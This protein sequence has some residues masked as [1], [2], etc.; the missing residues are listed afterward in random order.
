MQIM[1][2]GCG[3]VGYTL[4]DQLSGEEDH[5]IIVV[6]R[7]PDRISRV[8]NDFDV[9]GYVG[10]GAS[11]SVLKEA[12][13]DNTDLL[14]AVTDSD[15]RNLLCSLIAKKAGNCKAIA[16]VRNPIYSSEG[17]FLKRELGLAMII[18]PEYA[19]ASEMARIFRFPSAIKIDTFAK[20][21]IELLRFRIPVGNKLHDTPVS[22]IR[23]KLGCEVLVCMVQRG[24]EVFIPLGDFVLQEKDIVSIVAAPSRASQFFRK[25][26]VETNR[27]PNVLIVGGGKITFYLALRLLHAGIDVKIIEQNRQRCEELS[28]LLPKASI[29]CGDGTDQN[30]LLEEGL[31]QIRG[32]A[33]LTNFDEENI[34]LSLFAKSKSKAKLVTKV[35]RISFD[36]VIENLGL[37][38]IVYPKYITTEFII[39]YVRSMQ[40]SMGSNVENLYKLNDN[41]AEALEFLIKEESPVVG[42]P[43]EK[44]QLKKNILICG[45]NRYGKIII[46]GG[47]DKI[48]VGDSVIVV[49]TD[50]RIHDIL[51]I[52][53]D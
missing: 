17:E 13:I 18:N 46:P 22:N 1:I 16:R 52:L 15:E 23:G 29:I 51:D 43:L 3:K 25:I 6:D 35:N 50:Y 32:F 21:R 34:L 31:E 36:E 19:A 14:I 53:E 8:T 40:D 38:C 26:G 2:V 44:L 24:E 37:D 39:Q 12:D 10:D 9:M 11:Y 28:E 41:R 42:I 48:R 30:L 27:V 5:N 20:G 47:Q 45:I 33:A 7:N 49:V 4:A